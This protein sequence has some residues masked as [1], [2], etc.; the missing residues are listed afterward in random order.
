M[1]R[2]TDVSQMMTLVETALLRYDNSTDAGAP[3]ILTPDGEADM[4]IARL[5]HRAHIALDTFSGSNRPVV[6][7]AIVFAK[8]VVR[9]GLR[10]YVGPMFEQQSNFNHAVLDLIERAKLENE[11]LRN[12]VARLRSDAPAPAGANGAEV[13]VEAEAGAGA[14]PPG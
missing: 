6:G 13:Q 7:P 1:M 8:R 12:E 5:R 10:W 4:H 14:R 11:R 9:R 3:L 2:N